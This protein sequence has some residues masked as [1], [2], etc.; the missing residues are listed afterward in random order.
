MSELTLKELSRKP[1]LFSG[2]ARLC[3]GCDETVM[4]RMV[5][6]ATRGPTI[7]TNA[8]G[9]LEVASTIFPFT[10]WNLP[11]IHS[12]FENTAATASGLEAAIKAMRRK[13]EGPLADYPQIDII[14]FAGDGGTYD[15]GFQAL[16]GAI[17]RGHDFTYVLLDNEAYMNTGIQRSGGTPMGAATTTTPAGKVVPGKSETKKPI[18]DIIIA[19]G[20]PYVATLNSAWPLDVVK[21]TRKAIEVEGPT[22]LHAIVPCSRGWRYPPEKTIA[23]SRLATQSCVFPLFECRQEKGRPVYELSAPSLAIAKRPESKKPVE[24]YL[25]LQGRFR[26]LFRPERRDELIK[27][28]QESVDLRWQILCE[29][30]GV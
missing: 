3:A 1:E 15:I 9:C 24:A 12:A 23:I 14:G 21:K 19:H 25:E 22:F 28:I 8:T 4:V 2:G 5:M 17:E 30:A 16:S 13:K 6:K 18:D 29:K 11:W 20:T 27:A 10:A 26:H 7:V